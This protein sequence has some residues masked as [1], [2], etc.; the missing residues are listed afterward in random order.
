MRP[1][2]LSDLHTAA[3]I[4]RDHPPDRRAALMTQALEA[5]DTADRYRKKLRRGHPDF[6]TGT[7]SSA[8]RGFQ[9]ES[10]QA[11]C[12][13]AYLEALQ[14]VVA[15]LLAKRQNHAQTA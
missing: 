3:L 13:T 1:V 14:V 4:L 5:A 2:H 11:P 15:A 6:G 9:M 10:T 7:L 8:M 12:E